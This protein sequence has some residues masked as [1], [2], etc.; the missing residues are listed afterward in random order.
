MAVSNFAGRIA[1]VTGGGT[2]MGRELVRQLAAAGAHVAAC[3]LNSETLSETAELASQDASEG[4]RITTHLCNVTDTDAV[5]AFA[6]DVAAAHE[7]DHIN[8]LFNNAGISGGG[9]FVIDDQRAA[10]DKT[11]EVCWNGVL[12]CARAFMDLLVRS[13][14]AAMVNT[15]SI[16]G[17]W[18]TVGPS[19]PHTSYSAAKFA[20]KGLTE[21][22]MVDLALHA[23]HVSAHVVMPGHIG[24]SI[25]FNSI[26][27][28]GLD[29]PLRRKTMA[30]RGIPIDQFSD[31]EI[32][33]LV[34]DRNT[35]FRVDA[36]TTA[37]QAA[38]IILAGVLAGDWR[39]LVGEDAH[40][41]DTAVR[42]DSES[43]Y[44]PQF[45][46]RLRDAGHLQAIGT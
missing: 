24:T 26:E 31:A 5:A 32:E 20:V 18:A 34:V 44:E 2:G 9:S 41:I 3:D 7:T 25:A 4:V 38:Q 19:V 17:F 13:D 45:F 6:A 35:R 30:A 14:A 12:N 37:A 36:P 27:A 39:I 22:L 8:L 28:H 1:V 23:P 15:S 33:A 40:A 10:W 11:F 21:A 46:E 29:I 43:A 42:A 16:N